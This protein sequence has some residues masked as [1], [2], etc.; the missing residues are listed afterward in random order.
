MSFYYA[1]SQNSITNFLTNYNS[2]IPTTTSDLS[3][4]FPT[5]YSGSFKTDATNYQFVRLPIIMNSWPSSNYFIQMFIFTSYN[6]NYYYSAVYA[7]KQPYTLITYSDSQ[8]YQYG[9]NIDS[10]YIINRSGVYWEP[11]KDYAG[12]SF[13]IIAYPKAAGNNDGSV[14]LVLQ[15]S[16]GGSLQSA[17]D[18]YCS[19]QVL[20]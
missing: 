11:Y 6:T 9:A 14:Y 7:L 18:T 13:P 16:D 10:T 20:I 3:Y 2:T 5:M 12:S 15:T 1:A 17:D 19:I 4:H 8:I